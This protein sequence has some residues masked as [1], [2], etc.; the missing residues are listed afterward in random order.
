MSYLISQAKMGVVKLRYKLL[1]WKNASM[2]QSFRKRHKCLFSFYFCNKA[3]ISNYQI[4][5]IGTKSKLNVIRAFHLQIWKEG[6]VVPPLI[7][8]LPQ[9]ATP[10]TRPVFRGT[11]IVNITKLSTPPFPPPQKKREA[12][13]VILPLFHCRKGGGL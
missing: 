3:D 11:E 8:S 2:H 1:A 4:M 12:T 10:H 9:K 13:P 7:G 5:L 6:T